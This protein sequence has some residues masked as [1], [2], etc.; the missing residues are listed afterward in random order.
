MEI[1]CLLFKPCSIIERTSE[2][3]FELIDIGTGTFE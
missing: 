2:L 3:T 1:S